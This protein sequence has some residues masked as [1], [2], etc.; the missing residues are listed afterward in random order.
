MDQYKELLDE[1]NR[2]LSEGRLDEALLVAEKA[3]ADNA[4]SA[5]AYALLGDC[6]ER[7]GDLRGALEA[8][9]KVVELNPNSPL[10]RI[11]LAHLRNLFEQRTTEPGSGRRRAALAALAAVVMVASFGA[12]AAL[13]SQRGDKTTSQPV[14]EP[15]ASAPAYA[16]NTPMGMV[17]DR[18]TVT[19]AATTQNMPEAQPVN[20]PSRPTEEATLPSADRPGSAGLATEGPIGPLRVRPD[21]S[22]PP[23]NRP[24]ESNPTRP[25]TGDPEPSRV[26]PSESGS[27]SGG[28]TTKPPR[29]PVYEITSSSQPNKTGGAGST[30]ITNNPNDVSN[31]LRVARQSYA[32]GDY[33]RAAGAYQRALS[34]GADPATTNQRLGQC[35]ERLGRKSEAINA[36]RD[37]VA[38]YERR[39]SQG[40]AT[41]QAGLDACR[42]ALR[43][44]G[45]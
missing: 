1:G 26:R 8:Y 38:A 32:S 25:N 34:M 7:Q 20:R 42:Q 12:A 36:Y 35:Y 24:T 13:F 15:D 14:S 31:M 4:E 2:L 5:E 37:A 11:K 22:L 43:T 40:D 16:M 21:G 10:D 33:E 41:S 3:V 29:A 6:R 17:P 44:L 9:D 39:A 18:S 27:T 45:G 23:A 28:T 30:P 19:P